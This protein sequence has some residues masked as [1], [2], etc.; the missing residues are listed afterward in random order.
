MVAEAEKAANNADTTVTNLS[1]F[2]PYFTNI[3]AADTTGDLNLGVLR[4]HYKQIGSAN[5]P[6]NG[7]TNC[8][9]GLTGLSRLRQPVP[10]PWTWAAM[11]AVR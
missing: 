7:F 3:N 4:V 2:V 1:D 5:N 10:A 8:T 9:A 6:N 11:W